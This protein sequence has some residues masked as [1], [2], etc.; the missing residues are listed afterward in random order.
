MSDKKLW[1]IISIT[2]DSGSRISKS[3]TYGDCYDRFLKYKKANK[4]GDTLYMI[5]VLEVAVGRAQVPAIE[6]VKIE[7]PDF[8]WN[9]RSLV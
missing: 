4:T 2:K 6:E 8:L 9:V 5:Q 3:M 1:K 7:T